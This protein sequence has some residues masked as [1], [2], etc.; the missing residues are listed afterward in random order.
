MAEHGSDRRGASTW[1]CH[2]GAGECSTAA[3]GSG[4]SGAAP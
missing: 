2:P 1:N 3:L 4:A